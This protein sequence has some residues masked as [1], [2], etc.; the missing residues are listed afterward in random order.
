MTSA[1][2]VTVLDLSAVA[3]G[4]ALLPYFNPVALRKDLPFTNTRETVQANTTTGSMGILGDA[5]RTA[6]TSTERSERDLWD[7]YLT[8]ITDPMG[9]FS[10]EQV[11]QLK[12]VWTRACDLL[13]DCPVPIT[14]PGDEGS[15]QFAWDNGEKYIDLEATPE[16]K[17]YWYY[18]DRQTSEVLGTSDQP[19]AEIEPD[20]FKKLADVVAKKTTSKRAA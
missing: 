10:V 18:R 14:Q 9:Y 12:R 13:G 1:L 2:R 17:I 20:F 19:T 8:S 11:Q 3:I 4:L 5:I 16:G 7:L 6:Q 15:L